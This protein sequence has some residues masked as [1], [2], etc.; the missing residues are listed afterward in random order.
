MSAKKKMKKDDG[1]PARGMSLRDYFAGRALA[2]LADP[3]VMPQN[4][5]GDN[6]WEDGLAGSAYEIADAMLRER[7][8]A[9]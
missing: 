2:M 3:A 7:E 1:G 4:D 8:K 6:E 9:R 5:N